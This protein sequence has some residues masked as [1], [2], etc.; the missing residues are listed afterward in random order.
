MK[1]MDLN[2][3]FTPVSIEKP[4]HL[5]LNQ[6]NTVGRNITIHTPNTPIGDI[7]KFNI[8]I[9]GIPEDRNSPNKGSSSAPDRIREKLY[10][11]FKFPQ[12]IKID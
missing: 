8:A 6:D 4:N 7:S 2:D 3:Y 1:N 5:F 11:L 10:Q 9:L 12:R